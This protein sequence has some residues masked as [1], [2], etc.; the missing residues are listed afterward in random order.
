MFFFRRKRMRL[1]KYAYPVLLVLLLIP[2]LSGCYILK[3]YGKVRSVSWN[4]EESTLSELIENSQDY[5]ISYDGMY[6]SL[7]PLIM[8]DP[9]N[10]DKAM[11]NNMWPK[12]TDPEKLKFIV[13]IVKSST[14][15][16]SR[17][18]K[19]FD[20]NDQFYGYLFYPSC[21]PTIA[22]MDEKAL[23]VYDWSCTEFDN[24]GDDKVFLRNR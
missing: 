9:K 14:Y 22:V 1:S 24:D 15:S 13:G 18:S 5:T 19:V 3:N 8:F 20:P 10:D 6:G 16:Q 7:P 17:L 21:D 11:Q 2:L 4:L 23:F 12:D